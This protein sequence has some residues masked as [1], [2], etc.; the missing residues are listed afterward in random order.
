MALTDIDDLLA[1]LR[2]EKYHYV[3]ARLWQS[4]WSS[5]WVS[6]SDIIGF[7]ARSSQSEEVAVNIIVRFHR[8]VSAARKV[9][10]EADLRLFQFTDAAFAVSSDLLSLVKF[11]STLQQYCLAQ[12][13]ITLEDKAHPLAHHLLLVRTTIAHG[14]VL[15]LTQPSAPEELRT[16]GVSADALLAGTAVVEAYRIEKN[17]AGAMISFPCTQTKMIRDA[18]LDVRGRIER[19][20]TVLE[21]W[22]REPTGFAHDGVVDFPWILLRPVQDRPGLWAD[23]NREVSR[24]LGIL[25]NCSDLMAGE[26]IVSNLPL[27]V[28]KHRAGIVRHITELVQRL[29]SHGKL[30]AWTESVLRNELAHNASSNSNES[31]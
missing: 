13:A 5:A 4:D 16:L 1:H 23:S 24:K 28:A 6:F 11:S 19:P 27:A 12:N 21:Q 14:R 9:C 26:F 17:T 8:C 7:A 22:L 25:L 30:S 31:G 15:M 3:D 10:E 2:T 29:R 20:R 18:K